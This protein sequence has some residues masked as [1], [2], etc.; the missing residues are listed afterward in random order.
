LGCDGAAIFRVSNK[1]LRR[2]TVLRMLAAVQGEVFRWIGLLM[3]AAGLGCDQR[4]ERATAGADPVPV[5]A[6]VPGEPTQ[7]QSR[8]PTT[9]LYLGTHRITAEVARL[10]MQIRTG[11]MF[12]PSMGENEGMLFLFGVPHRAS[13][14]MKNVTVEL[15]VAYLD[16]EGRILEI[17]D[18]E[19]GN[20]TPVASRSGRVQYALEMPRG[21]F[22]RHG[23]TSG[24]LVT[25]EHGPLAALNAGRGR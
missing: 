14:W 6:S 1:V 18:L 4:A 17:H 9:E 22:D 2:A 25:T 12:R 8:L 5:R 24:V 23:V 19:P 15:S 7:A 11:M 21:W 16:P 13:F 10:P 20:E 3:L